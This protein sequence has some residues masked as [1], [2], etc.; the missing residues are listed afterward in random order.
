MKRLFII[1]VDLI[2]VYGGILMTFDFLEGRLE[3]HNVEAFYT[4]APFI[5]LLYL[6][7]MYVYGLYNMER[8]SLQEVI[9]IVFLISISLT[10][11]IMA[12][13]F[14]V[15]NIAFSYPRSVIFLSMIVYFVLLSIWRCLIWKIDKKSHGIRPVAIIGNADATILAQKIQ[16]KYRDIYQVKIVCEEND[17]GLFFHLENISEIFITSEVN[18]TIRERLFFYAIENEKQVFF[19]PKYSDIGI[20]NSVMFKTNDIPTYRI[21]KLGLSPEEQF[22]KRVYDL[23]FTLIAV[24]VSFPIGVIVALLVKLDGG[25]V[26][27]KQQRCTISGN[28]FNVLKFRTMIPDAERM[29]GPVLA[30]ENDPRIT[31]IGHFLRATRLDELPQLINILKGDMSIV[32][33][34]PERPY[35]V[36]SFEKNTPEYR[37]RMKVKAGLTGLAQVYGKYN[38]SSDEKLRYDLIYINNYTLLRDFLICLQTIKIL[39][40]KESTQGLVNPSDGSETESTTK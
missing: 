19:V 38:T 40:L 35:F 23:F 16:L 32:G 30:G 1:L 7:F 34:R 9:Y 28:L 3:Q 27:Y 24:I 15:R 20:M 21:P 31:K 14:F 29:S 13:C 37:Y 4:I 17:P 25:P 2:A 5:G 26:F 39:F 6:I 22:I 8:M 11:S 33:P 10:L 18:E 12:V 36:R